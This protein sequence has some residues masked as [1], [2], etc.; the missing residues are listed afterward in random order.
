MV[1][2]GWLPRCPRGGGRRR[3]IGRIGISRQGRVPSSG[4]PLASSWARKGWGAEGHGRE[5]HR[6]SGTAPRAC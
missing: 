2:D 1:C 6:H 4:L 3:H 5:W